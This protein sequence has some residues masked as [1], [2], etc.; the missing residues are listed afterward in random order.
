MS[1][2]LA[3]LMVRLL[4]LEQRFES[5]FKLYEEELGE[6]KDTL[7]SLREDVL[8][9]AQQTP[10]ENPDTGEPLF[11]VDAR[12]PNPKEEPPLDHFSDGMSV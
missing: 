12:N 10:E 1:K 2:N 11:P 5:Y 6:I 4:Q 7:Q 9:L 3:D 8:R